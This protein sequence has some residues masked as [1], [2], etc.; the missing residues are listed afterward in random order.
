MNIGFWIAT[1]AVL[2]SSAAVIAVAVIEVRR[3]LL[4]PKRFWARFDIFFWV[5][6][7]IAIVVLLVK[8]YLDNF[9]LK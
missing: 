6:S 1:I 3:D 7:C 2:I 9:V 5:T 4:N 8:S